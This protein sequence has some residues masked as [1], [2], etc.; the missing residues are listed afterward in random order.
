MRNFLREFEQDNP[1]YRILITSG[2]RSFA[3]QVILK[4]QNNSNASPGKSLHNYG[5]AIDLNIQNGSGTVIA[6]KHS[7][8]ST[9]YNTGIVTLAN[10]KGITWGG[11]AFGTYKDRVHFGLDGKID[12]DTV[13]AIAKRQF[14]NN[15]SLIIGNKVDFT[16]KTVG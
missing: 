5:L 12:M 14:G 9:W 11:T 10:K 7:S 16:G 6:S 8:D 2:Y 13:L 1:Q 4:A 15:L 3:E